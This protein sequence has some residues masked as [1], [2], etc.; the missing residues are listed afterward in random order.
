MCPM[1]CLAGE[2]EVSMFCPKCGAKVPDGARFC[3]S[4][5]QPIAHQ[6]E[7]REPEQVT[8]TPTTSQVQTA[9]AGTPVR[10]MPV[11]RRRTVIAVIVAAALVVTAFLVWSMWYYLPIDERTFPGQTLRQYV[12]ATYDADRDGKLSRPERDAATTLDLANTGV[13]SLDG[14]GQLYALQSVD[15][16]SCP[17]LPSLDVS[18]LSKLTALRCD[19]ACSVT[20]VDKTQVE[21]HWVQSGVNSTERSNW[22]NS[23]GSTNSSSYSLELSLGWDASGRVSSMD[24]SYSSGRDESLTYEYDDAGRLIRKNNAITYSSSSSNSPSTE[25]VTYSY[26][27]NGLIIG[28]D[29]VRSGSTTNESTA[30]YARDATGKV[31][32]ATQQ[33]SPNSSPSTSSYA[34]DAAGRLIDISY[35]GSSGQTYDN[36]KVTY[37]DQ[38]RVSGVTYPTG[39]GYSIVAYAYDDQGRKASLNVSYLDPEG[40]PMSSYSESSSFTYDDQGRLSGVN[41]QSSGTYYSYSRDTSYE[42]GD[43]GL[44]K[45]TTNAGSSN[46]SSS[47]YTVTH[48]LSYTRIF[49]AKGT[50]VQDEP[51]TIVPYGGETAAV[52]TRNVEGVFDDPILGYSGGYDVLFPQGD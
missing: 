18:D 35:A 29:D 34:Y 52:M 49:V 23:S 20:G 4:C 43:H 2:G 42:Y 10:R 11:G 51:L 26:D 25:S 3:G 9:S 7:S 17:S 27:E 14:I 19:D 46:S 6:T 39:D 50:A 13:T 12:S 33:Y 24:E 22:A 1:S 41:C 21:E 28:S 5:G 32:T 47:T 8:Q 16:S 37:D 38:G 30:T 15:V 31:T 44:S 45:V 36:L 40:K 48:E